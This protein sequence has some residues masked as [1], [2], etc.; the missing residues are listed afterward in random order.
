M[1]F[2]F[3]P[4]F[5][6]LYCKFVRKTK[7]AHINSIYLQYL[8]VTSSIKINGPPKTQTILNTIKKK[9]MAYGHF[10]QSSLFT[11][12]HCHYILLT[13]TTPWFGQLPNYKHISKHKINNSL[14][15]VHG[16][17]FLHLRSHTQFTSIC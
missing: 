17:F 16:M 11:L 12:I 1:A 9:K 7:G 14:H 10:T 4:F 2:L 5:F 15:R 8:S 13:L 6:F 3:F